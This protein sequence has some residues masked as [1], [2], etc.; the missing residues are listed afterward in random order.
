[1]KASY[2][3]LLLT[4]IGCQQRIRKEQTALPPEQIQALSP[5]ALH[6]R[7]KSDSVTIDA[8]MYKAGAA[9]MQVSLCFRHADTASVD[10]VIATAFGDPDDDPEIREDEAG[11]AVP[12]MQYRLTLP[13]G[14]QCCLRLPDSGRLWLYVPKSGD[15][16]NKVAY[17]LERM[18]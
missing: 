5:P 3:L 16:G 8:R 15:N 9:S 6:Y 18:Y 7:Y 17:E 13:V 12:C 10:C 11:N 1:M 14:A 4:G 2:F